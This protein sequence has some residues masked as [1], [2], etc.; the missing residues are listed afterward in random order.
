MNQ[1]TRTSVIITLFFCITTLS[2]KKEILTKDNSVTSVQQN[3]VLLND[4]LSNEVILEWSNVAF[5]TLGGAFEGHPLLASRIKA[6]MHIAMHD[7]LNAITPVYKYYTYHT[8]Q[9]NLADPFAAAVSASH[10]VLK[11]SWPDSAAMLDARLAAS[12]AGIPDGPAKT[13]GIEI[14]IAS[15]NGNNISK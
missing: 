9:C 13:K 5:E 7:A 15:G 10:T 11:A 4:N 1:I 2:C 12:L 8:Q 6:M 3:D 14:G